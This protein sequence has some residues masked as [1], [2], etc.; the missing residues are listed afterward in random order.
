L[1]PDAAALV[2]A[3]KSFGS[4]HDASGSPIT[5]GY[6]HG[7]GGN[8]TFPGTDP[9]LFQTVVG[10]RGILGQLPVTPS[11]FTNPTYTVV[12]GV[13][14]DTGDE[15]NGVCDDAPVAGLMK[16]GTITSVFGRYERSTPEMELNR[17]GQYNDRADPMDLAMMG[18]PIAESGLF[19]TGPG[20][21]RPGSNVLEN[22]ISRKMWEKGVSFMR[23]LAQQ[24]YVG[25]PANNSAGGGYKE[26]TGLQ[27]LVNTGYLDVET[28]TALPSVDS[29]LIDF[30]YQSVDGDG[31]GLVNAVS[32]IWRYLSDLAFRTGVNPVRW[33][34]AMRPDLFWEIT[35]V[36]PCAY[37]TYRCAPS[38]A[39]SQVY[40]EATEQVRLRDEMRQ[41]NYL[42]V[43]GARIPVYLDDGIPLQDGNDSGGNF[44]A[45][46]F[47]SDIYFLPFSVMGGQS[48]LYMEH[49]DYGNPSLRAALGTDNLILARAEGPWLSVPKR[50]NFCFQIQTKIEPRLVL[51]TPWLAARLQNVVWC[52]TLNPRQPFPADPYF[53]NGGLVNRDGPSY[54]TP[55]NQ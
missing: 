40:I 49:F 54:F 36:W 27:T 33:G 44:P 37:L 29:Q 25:N 11:V 16:A 19:A 51:R 42:L 17:L 10:N 6:S 12:T 21:P 34:I 47:A 32:Y 3:L 4:K 39:N 24:L 13:K 5:V 18:S 55:W 1:S 46:C 22:E 43:D 30:N 41:G 53:V 14:A 8:L 45:G 15:K 35:A 28:G 2:E 50:T 31:S 52:P 20:N 26:M 38:G 48:V 23:L 9:R 7:P